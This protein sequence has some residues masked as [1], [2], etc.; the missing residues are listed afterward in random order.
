VFKNL[1]ST[2][3]FDIYTALCV[4]EICGE[5]KLTVDAI[6]ISV[7]FRLEALLPIQ[8]QVNSVMRLMALPRRHTTTFLKMVC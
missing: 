7:R 3:D 1:L 2:F 5:I 4:S 6:G 8:E